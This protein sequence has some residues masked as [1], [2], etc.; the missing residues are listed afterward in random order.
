MDEEF[1]TFVVHIAALEALLA[2]MI[3]YP[4]WEAQISAPIQDKAPTKVSP[5]YADYA[6]VFAFDLAMEL[7]ENTGINR[8]AIELED[9]KQPLYRP[10]YSLG[11]IELETLKTYIETYLKTC[12]ALVTGPIITWLTQRLLIYALI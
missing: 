10:I 2:G 1:E 3:I 11:P 8:H 9:G 12:N 4:L 7:P 6:D 5:K